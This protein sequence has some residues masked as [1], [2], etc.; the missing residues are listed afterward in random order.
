[1]MVVVV[2]VMNY[3]Q[4]DIAITFPT[5]EYVILFCE[6]TINRKFTETNPRLSE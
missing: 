4:K 2:V 3:N 6:D 1:M 5:S